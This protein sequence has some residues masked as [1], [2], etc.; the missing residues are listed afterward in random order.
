MRKFEQFKIEE[1]ASMSHGDLQSRRAAAERKRKMVK[2][3]MSERDNKQDLALEATIRKIDGELEKID[4]ALWAMEWMYEQLLAVD[5]EGYEG[6][7]LFK[8]A[9]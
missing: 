2:G 5:P 8:E 1:Y 4:A 9:V 6:S 7:D 3:L